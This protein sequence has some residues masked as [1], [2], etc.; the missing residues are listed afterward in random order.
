MTLITKTTESGKSEADNAWPC[1]S[2]P[3][4]RG[5]DARVGVAVLGCGYWGRNLVRNFHSLGALACICD[6]DHDTADALARQYEVERRDLDAVL[7]DDDIE[8][9]VIAA[10]AEQHH[11]L[12]MAAI[13]AGKHVFVEKPIA[14]NMADA[15]EICAAAQKAGV[16]LMV[17]HLLQY[18]PAFLR[19][20]EVV[21]SGELGRLRYVYSRRL[22]IGK[23]RTHENVLWSFAPHDI[24][25][26]LALIDAEPER[27]DGFG[28]CFLQDSISD[29]HNVRLTFPGGVKAHI[30]VSWLNPFKEQRLV[31]VGSDAMVEFDDQAE[32]YE[33]LKI[34]KHRAE[35]VNGFPVLEPSPAD[36][37]KV[38]PGEPLRNEC[39]HFLKFVRTGETPYTDGR[40]A[41]RVLRVLV[42]ADNVEGAV[43]DV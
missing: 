26:I 29:F 39:A 14:L 42:E 24:S 5:I 41:M 40:E 30:D 35:I 23:L 2:N 7:A 9:V 20:K 19:L 36:V 12:A 33:K 31:V 38:T 43:G 32:W 3:S 1:T 25:M 13:G 16:T 37:I 21:R 10:P 15:E 22:N 18:H 8:A 34:Y 6:T 11:R 17:G 4:D 27:I 28:G